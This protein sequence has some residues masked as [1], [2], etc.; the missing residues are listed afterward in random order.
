MDKH[1]SHLSENLKPFDWWSPNH[2]LE[3][4]AE[5]RLRSW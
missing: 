1:K 3:G 5:H 2:G 4:M